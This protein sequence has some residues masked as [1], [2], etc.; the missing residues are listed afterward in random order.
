MSQLY[1]GK[2]TIGQCNNC[3][4]II[5]HNILHAVYKS[6]KNHV[7]KERELTTIQL[8]AAGL[9]QF[10]SNIFFSSVRKPLFLLDQYNGIEG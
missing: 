5:N 7:Y 10:V 3:T 6:F 1:V 2:R 8:T 4:F 9:E